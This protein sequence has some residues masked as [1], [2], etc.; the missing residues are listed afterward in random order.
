[1]AAFPAIVSLYAV[2]F[3][4]YQ[5]QVQVRESSD[6]A[7]P[8]WIGNAEGRQYDSGTAAHHHV[9]LREVPYCSSPFPPGRSETDVPRSTR[10]AARCSDR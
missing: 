7:V 1:M 6:S 10:A 2:V 4:A 3:S 9:D 8:R 5:Y